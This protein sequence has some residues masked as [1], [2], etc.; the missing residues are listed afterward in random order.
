MTVRYN[1]DIFLA[2]EGPSFSLEAASLPDK[3]WPRA[4]E[5]VLLSHGGDGD[6]AVLDPAE[7]EV[8]R[9]WLTAWLAAR[10]RA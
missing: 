1:S 8:L 4:P 7:V 2:I 10:G 9:D 3:D 6:P 5:G